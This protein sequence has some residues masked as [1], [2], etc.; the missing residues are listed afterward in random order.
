M[1]FSYILHLGNR[2]DVDFPDVLRFLRDDENTDVV[3]MYVEGTD[4]GRGIFEELK[5]LCKE[6]KVVVMKSGKSSV[7][8]K[9]SVSHTGSMAGDYR[10]FTSAMRQAGAVVAETPIELMDTAIAMERFEVNGGV[11]VLTIQ[12]GLGIVAADIIESSGGRLARFGDETVRRLKSLLP[13]ITLRENPVDM[14]FSGLDLRVFAEVIDAVCRDEDVGL[15]MFLYAVAP[16]SW[17]LRQR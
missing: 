2:C 15:V 16:P 13:P 17:V 5:K 3:A 8:D 9:A 4:N 1:G 6:K 11:A 10:V 14:S 7:A 12:A